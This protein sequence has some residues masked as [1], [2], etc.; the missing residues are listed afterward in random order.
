MDLID[1]HCHLYTFE[2]EKIP[3]I[4][5]RAKEAHVSRA[6]CIGAGHGL[7][8]AEKSVSLAKKYDNVFASV[9]IHPHDAAADVSIRD[10][11]EYADYNK[12]VAIGETGLDFF[13]DWSP[14]EEQ[15]RLFE[16]TVAFAKEIKKPLIIHCRDAL[17]ETLEV[18]IKNNAKEVGGVFHCYAGDEE[19]AKKILDLNFIIS[20][21]GTLTFKKAT[22]FRNTVKEIPLTQIMLET[23]APYMAP[24]PYRGKKSE[25]AHVLEI[26]KML[27]EIKEVS[28]AE[29]A[30]KTTANAEHLFSLT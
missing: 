2:D 15:Y 9:G 1:T 10:V 6:I 14:K 16:E 27:S 7:V 18:L 11:A 29:V 19:F 23:D 22:E 30:K 26:A 5:A 24:E 25:P 28:L 8:S 17:N 20:I 13:R 4:L 3:A 12:V 21:T